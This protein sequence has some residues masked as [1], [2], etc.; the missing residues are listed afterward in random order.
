MTSL[1]IAAKVEEIYPP[2]LKELASHIESYASNTEQAIS[3][4]EIYM[5]KTLEWRI[6]PVTPNTWLLAY[7]QIS[8][9]FDESTK[10]HNSHYV[11]PMNLTQS[12]QW[13]VSSANVFKRESFFLTTYLKSATLL[14]LCL[15][16]IESLR[17][18]YSE[19]AAAALYLMMP[20][21][22]ASDSTMVRVRLVEKWTGFTWRELEACVNWMLPYADVC[23][24]FITDEKM[25]S[26]RQFSS[27]EPDDAHNIQMYHK[28]FD[29]WVSWSLG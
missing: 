24:D 19:L 7:L 26:V 20:V 5:L 2:K 15:M 12:Y 3:E 4:F 14:D 13:S 6:S 16:D 25:V 27:V 9:T 22:P 8:S 18:R 1:F 11:M 17:F 23:R 21:P 29:L 10:I 28:Y